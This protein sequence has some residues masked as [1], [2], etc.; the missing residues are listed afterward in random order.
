M[1]NNADFWLMIILMVI[2]SYLVMSHVMLTFQNGIYNHT[3]KIYMALLMGC[4]MGM[5]HYIIMIWNG[6]RSLNI[7]YGLVIW[8]IL[9]IIFIILIRKQ[10]MIDDEEFLKGMI[11][12]HDMALLMSEKI[13]NKT[14]DLQ[15]K[16]FAKNIISSQQAEINW[17]KN[18]L[19][20]I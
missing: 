14:N 17:M 9:T 7:W 19:N 11:E 5:I 8:T 6:H 16:N 13:I 3:N 2:F 10:S 15:V 12:H 4:L 1:N 20:N 18:K